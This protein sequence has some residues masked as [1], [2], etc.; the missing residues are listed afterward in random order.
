M[1]RY[2]SNFH[3]NLKIGDNVSVVRKV[4]KEDVMEFAKLSSDTNP[5]HFSDEK[6]V[7][8]GAFLNGL[9][10][11]VIGTRLPGPGTLVITQTLNFP[12]KCF[13]GD[14][15]TINVELVDVRKIIKVKFT[16]KTDDSVVLYG[17]AKL[18]LNK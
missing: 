18:V 11:G 4:T 8:H 17:D 14:T 5:I 1:L 10:S 3:G 13:T 9:V 15:V 7:V 12:N 6:A 16:C 2:F